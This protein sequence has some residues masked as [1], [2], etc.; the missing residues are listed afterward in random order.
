MNQNAQRSC[1]AN[2]FTLDGSAELES[3]LAS[4]CDRVL[5][6]VKSALPL[7][8]LEALVL[9][10]GY[11]RGEGGVLATAAADQPYNDLEFYVFLRGNRL[12]NG[13]WYR[14]RVDTLA[15]E[16]ST[17]ARLHVEFKLDSLARLRRSSISMFS[18]DLVSGHRI[19]F[20]DAQVFAGCDHHLHGDRIPLSEATRLLFNRCTGLLLAKEIL[21]RQEVLSAEE[22]DFVG[23]NLAKA[24]LALGDAV[25]T[26]FRQYHW[27]G[28][29]RHKRLNQL[30]PAEA[31]PSFQAL[32]EH[33]AKGLHFKL[34]PRLTLK[35][36]SDFRQE[37]RT[38]ALLALE[39]WL[40]L[41]SK[42]LR[43]TFRS[44]HEYVHCGLEK[45]SE[46]AKWRNCLLNLRSLGPGA[47]LGE[48]GLRYPRER[49]FNAL[50]LLL[51]NGERSN[52]PDAARVLQRTLHTRASDWI[53]LVAAY[54]HIWAGYG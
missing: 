30:V 52:S 24:Q 48:F 39:I 44:V 45:C 8:R 34:H 20:G 40:W 46:T 33:H 2:R 14:K 1:E 38:I 37:H 32:R 54:K 9:A 41:E 25:L 31:V 13:Q 12:L 18:Y 53:S 11:G 22:Q 5:E 3:Q 23:R 21:E 27:S 50:P 36:T 51:W 4:T 17:G 42:R 6:A 10:G 7:A 49:L 29:E 28:L 19:V 47:V 16:L 35:S 43:H 26:T 15:Q